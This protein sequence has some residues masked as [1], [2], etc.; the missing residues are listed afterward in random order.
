MSNL[1]NPTIICDTNN[2]SNSLV[3]INE[4]SCSFFKMSMNF[5]S[6]T[7]KEINEN[8][9]ILYKRILESEGDYDIVNESFSDFFNNALRIIEK[10]IKFIRNMVDKFITY[11]FNLCKSEKFIR[12]RK[13]EFSKFTNSNSFY[14]E[15]FNYTFD[16]NIPI[17]TASQ[18]FREDFYSIKY[19]E[20]V[21]TA[22]TLLNSK[23]LDGFYDEFRATVIGMDGDF[24]SAS[25]FGIELFRVYRNGSDTKEE[26][27]ADKSFVEK[28][29]DRFL[30]YNITEKSVKDTKNTIE[31]QYEEIKKFI[32]SSI[33][34]KYGTNTSIN[35]VM[36]DNPEWKGTTQTGKEYL[37]YLNL[38]VKTKIN[39]I[40][41]MSNIH[42]LAFG[43][44]LD[45]LKE[46]YNQDRMVLYTALKNIDRY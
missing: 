17:I 43:A 4:P 23:L 27:L 21:K 24:I 18:E 38:F 5:I 42:A 3:D 39:Q 6:N 12:D 28:S 25:D 11:L 45:A 13:N 30:N 22:Y 15:G 26:I 10:F 34:I 46:C 32:K 9:R 8:A 29:L 19:I 37:N 16:E 31:K 41:Q 35:M 36:Q 40:E 33:Q 2:F 44:K 14:F 20:D 7:Q 1:F